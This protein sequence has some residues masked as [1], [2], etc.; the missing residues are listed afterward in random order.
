MA[1]QFYMHSTYSFWLVAL[2]LVVATLASYTALDLAGRISRLTQSRARHAWLAGGAAAMGVG[3]WSMH[4]IGMLAVSLP[5]PL[6]YDLAI[7][8]YSLVIAILVSWFALYV[9]TR[10]KL[11]PLRLITGG[12]LMGFGIAG[13]HYTG[14]AAMQMEP[15]IHY[16]PKLFAASILIAIVASN[17]ALWI[18]HTLSDTDQGHVVQKRIGAAFVMGL[19][20]TGMHYTGMAAA[21]FPLGSICG[22]ARGVNS[23]WLATSVTLF[24]FAILIVVLMM[25]RFDARTTFLVGSVSQLNGQIVRM[26]T[27]DTL[28][29]LPNRRT[30]TERIEGAIQASGRSRKAFAILFMD[31]DGFKTINDSL[32]HSVGDEVLKAFAQRLLH[33]VRGGD[34]VARL[35]GDEFVVLLENLASPADAEKMAESVLDRMRKG[36][37]TDGQ[38]LQVT[39]SIGISLFPQ[40]GDSVDAL[41]KNADAAMYEAKRGGRGTYR[42]F[43]AGM[44]EAA[45]RTLQIQNALHEA[46][47]AGYFSL[48]FQPKFRGDDGELAGAEALLRLNHPELGLLAPLEF[49]PIAERSG[50]IVQ[51]GHWVVRETCRQIRRWETAGLPSMKVAINLSPRQLVQQDLVAT[52]LEIVHAEQ[53]ACEQI[54]FEITETVAMQDAPKTIEMIHAFQRNGFEIAIDD[55]GTGYSSLAY[56]QRF[57]VKQLKIDR[58]FTNGLDDHGHEGGAIVSAIIALAHSLEMDVVAEGVETASQLAKLK[59]MMCDEMQGFLL[60]KPLT[61]EAFAALLT[62]RAVNS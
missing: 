11:S 39:P 41:L 44:N 10:V 4:F 30:L 52:I 17:A 5:I 38:P 3:I 60:G 16:D 45:T 47:D 48:H 6:G 25:S 15:G 33:C 56:L 32:G 9:V 21:D 12:I 7:T 20:I 18:A 22:A 58:F 13:M 14:M 19:A 1:F 37:W 23:Q 50:Q 57:R 26:A 54:M 43:E 31:L 8:S 29:D 49:I 59:S 62:E 24:T 28:T 55:F 35:G 2:S 53:V 46:L 40:D 51:I 34:T 42:F 61:A 27:F 36:A